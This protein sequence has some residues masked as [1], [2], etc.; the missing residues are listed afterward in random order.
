MGK[1][2]HAQIHWIASIGPSW[3]SREAD[4]VGEVAWNRR[5]SI[6]K[7]AAAMNPNADR[8]AANI[9]FIVE[10]KYRQAVPG[11]DLSVP[12]GVGY[13]FLGNSSVVPPFLGKKVGDVSVGVN[14]ATIPSW[15]SSRSRRACSSSPSS[16]GA[17]G[18]R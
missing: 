17:S 6:S 1:S 12:V 13:G 16:C 2:L 10:P 4:F 9:R 7:N 11:L 3:L 15:S 8:D 5:L 18:S 14:R